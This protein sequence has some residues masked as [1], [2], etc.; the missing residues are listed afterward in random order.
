MEDYF[1]AKNSNINYSCRLLCD[2]QTA[3]QLFKEEYL[4]C[5]VKT[6]TIFQPHRLILIIHTD[7]G[8]AY[9]SLMKK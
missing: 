9:C 2:S 3:V 8:T 5:C 1:K 6:M 7:T 4:K